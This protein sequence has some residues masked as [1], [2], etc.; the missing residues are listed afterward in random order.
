MVIS[1][2]C[3]LLP[4]PSFPSPRASPKALSDTSA[5]TASEQEGGVA[6]REN[7]ARDQTLDLEVPIALT[8]S[9]ITH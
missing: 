1:C 2:L 7:H 9:R 8:N 4:A 3:W 5:T 6:G